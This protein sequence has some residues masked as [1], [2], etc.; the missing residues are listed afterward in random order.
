MG[1]ESQTPN[2]APGDLKITQ[3]DTYL[4]LEPKTLGAIQ[5]LIGILTLCLSATL[6]QITEL[7]FF[8]DI[9]ILLLFALEIILSG[10]ILITTGLYPTLLWL[11]AMLVVHL[12]SLAFTTAALGLLSKNLPFRQLSYHCEHCRRFEIFSVLLID[13]ILGTLVLF[14]IVEL[15]ICI[16]AILVGLS[17]L[18][19]GGI[20]LPGVSQRLTTPPVQVQPVMVAPAQM[21]QVSVVVTEPQAEPERTPE[22]KPA[23]KPV[24]AAVVPAPIVKVPSPPMESTEPQVVPIEPQVLSTEPQV[25]PIE[26]QVVPI[27]PQVV[28]ME[29][30]VVSM[31]P[32]VVPLEPQVEPL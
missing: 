16:V 32:Q 25:V 30:Q 22:P 5:V 27:E 3:V 9:V 2:P 18:A 4:R 31:E 7:H 1:L 19:Q 17:V 10:C 23:P 11:K 21:A 15:V 26:P 24:H 28:M 14:L 6:L 20:Q 29:P 8:G 13:G 12:V